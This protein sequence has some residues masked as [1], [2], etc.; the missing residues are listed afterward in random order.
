MYERKQK[1]KRTEMIL[2]NI[3]AKETEMAVLL[4][5][6]YVGPVPGLTTR[7]VSGPTAATGPACLLILVRYV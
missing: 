3:H 6:V 4:I 7:I 2:M 1:C 5:N